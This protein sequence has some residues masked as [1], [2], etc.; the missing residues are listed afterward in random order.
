MLNVTDLRNLGPDELAEKL[1][2]L[3]KS[4]MQYRFQSKTGKLETKNILKET[5]RDIARVL[6]VL[7]QTKKENKQ[8]T[9]K[10]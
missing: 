6:T 5:K 4:L 2:Q 9:S 7:N 3:K 10:P 8:E 1:V